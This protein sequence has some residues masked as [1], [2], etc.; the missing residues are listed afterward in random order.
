MNPKEII[1]LAEAYYQV[2]EIQELTE[3]VEIA[4]EYF[5]EMGLNENGIDI[6]VEELGEDE[7]VAWVYDI[8]EEYTLSEARRSGRIEPVTKGGKS[9]G[10]LKGGAKTAA[11]SRL[12][13]E[14][15]AS[16]SGEKATSSS[17]GMTTALRS[18]AAKSSASKQKPTKPQEAPAQTKRGIGGFI[19][20]IVQRAKDDTALLKKSVDTARGV[21]ARRG[22][23]VKAVYDTARAKGKEVEQTPQATRARRVATVAAGRTAQAV[24]KAAVKTAGATGAAVGAGVAARRKGATAAQTAG[25]VAGTFAKKI[26]EEVDIYD[27]ILS[28]LLDEGYADTEESAT[29]IMVSMSEEWRQDIMERDVERGEEDNRREVKAHNKSLKGKDGKPLYPSGKAGYSKK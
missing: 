10:S 3:E 8:A 24:G 9:I 21:A 12:R 11:I 1:G 14:K 2:Y 18:Q 15:E 19:G 25:R 5:Y 13:R 4:T 29:A 26:G 17:S 28:H 22:A 16:R 23:E 7:F 6:L 27:I 20:S